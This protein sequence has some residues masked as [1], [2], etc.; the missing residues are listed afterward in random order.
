MDPKNALPQFENEAQLVTADAGQLIPTLETKQQDLA[1]FI[2]NAF[3][4]E[5]ALDDTRAEA[6]IKAALVD[7]PCWTHETLQ[8]IDDV[9]RSVF[10][11]FPTGIKDQTTWT[12][13]DAREIVKQWKEAATFRT[14][15]DAHGSADNKY[16]APEQ[17]KCIHHH[18]V[19]WFISAEADARQQKEPFNKNKSRAEARLRR[20]C[21]HMHMVHAIWAVGLPHTH[22]PSST[23]DAIEHI[24]SNTEE[25]L[26]WLLYIA[27]AFLAHKESPGYQMQKR[28]SG[29]TKETGHGLTAAEHEERTEARKYRH[30]QYLRRQWVK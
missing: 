29:Q 11:E 7:E 28:K 21:G 26:D 3:T 27:K 16:F 19:E 5:L 2:I 25:I 20:L 18:Y 15:A 12:P 23:D 17:V 6:I 9:F 1:Y 30:A 14:Y 13:R 4:H 24:Q 10:F 22:E 8:Q